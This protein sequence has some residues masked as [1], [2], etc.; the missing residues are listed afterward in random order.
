MR[1]VWFAFEL[2]LQQKADNT[3]RS[4]LTKEEVVSAGKTLRMSEEDI[5]EALQYFHKITIILY[6]PDVLPD[7]VFVDQKPILDILSHLLALTYVN[8]GSLHYVANKPDQNEI[9]QL[10]KRVYLVNRFFLS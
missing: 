1:I 4:Y 10:N 5:E 7:I 9:D 2:T 3:K 6:Y 8:R